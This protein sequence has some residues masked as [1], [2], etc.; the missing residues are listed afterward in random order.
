MDVYYICNSVNFSVC[1]KINHKILE[2][3]PMKLIRKYVQFL[4]TV[5]KENEQTI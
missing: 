3:N 2:K 4:R 5:K 1:L